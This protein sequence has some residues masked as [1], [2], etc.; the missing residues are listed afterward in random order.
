MA[1]DDE[2]WVVFGTPVRNSGEDGRS[3]LATSLATIMSAG[4]RPRI[5]PADVPAEWT[6]YRGCSGSY[7]VERKQIRFGVR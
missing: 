2:R 4:E 7:R 1:I 5:A 3:E 6:S